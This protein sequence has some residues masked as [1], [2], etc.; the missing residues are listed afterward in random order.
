MASLQY[1]LD[2]K[3]TFSSHTV[4][5][6]K[7]AY[8]SMVR[9]MHLPVQG[10]QT[11]SVVGPFFWYE[12]DQDAA[13][14][15][16]RKF[17]SSANAGRRELECFVFREIEIIF[18]K[19]DV[20]WPTE[21]RGFEMMLTHD[22]GTRTTSGYLK[23]TNREEVEDI[24]RQ[25]DSC[26][27]GG[28]LHPL[29]LPT[30]FLTTHLSADNDENQRS[31]RGRLRGLEEALVQR[32][33]KPAMAGLQ[34]SKQTDEQ[35]LRRGPQLD[36]INGELADLHCTAMWKRPQAW[37]KVVGRA[38]EAAGL[39]WEATGAAGG[40]AG[41][42]QLERLHGDICRALRLLEVKLEG[43]ESYTHVSLE[44]LN[45]Q[46]QVVRDF[47]AWLSPVVE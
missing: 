36:T 45:L 47:R 29:L 22:F 15:R 41:T 24:L 3:D 11:S 5:L 26:S 20:K 14:P 10:I 44:R 13:N 9:A 23:G 43:L 35:L 25:L 39:F 32:Y 34:A 1:D 33:A 12:L 16:L 40:E 28:A 18:R 27:R 21:S 8:E 19:S 4:S 31:I 7:D 6:P 30:L 2:D 17:S 42:P 38:A 37:Q 46:R